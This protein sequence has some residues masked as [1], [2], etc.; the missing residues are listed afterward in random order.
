LVKEYIFD[1]SFIVKG[2]VIPRRRKK[3]H[4]LNQ[5]LVRHQI[6]KGY[7]DQVSKGKVVM[8][9]PSLALVETAVVI[10]RLTN[11][12]DEAEKAILFLRENSSDIFY[13]VDILDEAISLGVEAK[14]RSFDVMFLAVAKLTHSLLLTD[15]KTMHKLAHQIGLES[16]LLREMTQ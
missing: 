5:E 16:N 10:A 9:I 12:R 1:T 8:Y 15:D 13:D 6:A 3:D 7:L 2:L 11:S 4:I 14:A